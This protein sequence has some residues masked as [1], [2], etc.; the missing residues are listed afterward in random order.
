M[1]KLARGNRGS[2]WALRGTLTTGLGLLCML[3]MPDSLA[4]ECKLGKVMEFPITMV[5]LRPRV[6]AKINGRDVRFMVD[7][8]A[9]FSI[10]SPASAAELNLSTFAAPFGFFVRGVNGSA[11][12]SITKVKEFTL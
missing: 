10:I 4:G 9:F 12:A 8:G 6:T 1:L 11:G 7:S 3:A 5:D 2:S